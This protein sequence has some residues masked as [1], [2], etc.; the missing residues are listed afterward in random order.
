MKTFYGE[1]VIFNNVFKRY[2]A[3]LAVDN[4]NLEIKKSEFLTLLGPSGSGKTTILNMIAGF[5]SQDEG[6]IKIGSESVHNLPTEKRNVGMVF[7]NYSLFPHMNIFENVA[8]PLKM[9]NINKTKIKDKVHYALDLV[10]LKD[11]DLR[12]PHELSG[13]QRQRVAFARAI[14]FEPKVLLMDEPLGALD[15]KL[16]ERMQIEIKRYHKE[17]GCTVIYVTH[18]QGEALTLSDRIVIMNEGKI[19]QIDNPNNIYDKPTS[20]FSANFIGE[21]NI[22]NIKYK[23][24]ENEHFIEFENIQTNKEEYSVSSL[25]NIPNLE[26]KFISV[27]PEKFKIYD[28]QLDINKNYLVCFN[29]IINEIIF[30][31]DVIKYICLNDNNYEI[32]LKITR[33][34]LSHIFKI[35]EKIKVSFDIK[36]A[37]FLSI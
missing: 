20:K 29:L 1:P 25:N 22:F 26:Y 37:V 14:V 3:I 7:Q 17:I 5:I 15:L 2:G 9:R 19:I 4:F 28:G 13:G 24:H 36:E 10:R 23:H 18:D 30:L 27:R 31:G 32:I 21:T 12:M 33:T 16:R 6:G 35:N 34:D 8:F 11:F